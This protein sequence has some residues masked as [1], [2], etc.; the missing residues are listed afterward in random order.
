MSLDQAKIGLT[1]NV[2]KHL[3]KD[4]HP[5][6]WNQN[7]A[8]LQICDSLERLERDVH[9]LHAKLQPLLKEVIEDQHA[10]QRKTRGD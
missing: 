4:K 7:A 8:L 1:E 9:L 2:R 6:L 3:A 10:W 5:I